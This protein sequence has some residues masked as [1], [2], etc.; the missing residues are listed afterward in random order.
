MLTLEKINIKKTN[1]AHNILREINLCTHGIKSFT[2]SSNHNSSCM[3]S[4]LTFKII[5][6]N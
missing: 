3:V 2:Q 1:I 4:L 5:I 6:L